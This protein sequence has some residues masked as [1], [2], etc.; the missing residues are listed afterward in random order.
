MKQRES[1]VF[2]NAT[3]VAIHIVERIALGRDA[4]AQNLHCTYSRLRACKWLNGQVGCGTLNVWV[5]TSPA[6]MHVEVSL[7]VRAVI[8]CLATC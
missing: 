1:L 8:D 4:S 5:R 3:I 6:K 7:P 2:P